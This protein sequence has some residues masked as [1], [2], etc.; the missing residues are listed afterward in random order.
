M[1]KS[2]YIL[3]LLLYLAG[4]DCLSQSDVNIIDSKRSQKS[5]FFGVGVGYGFFYPNDVNDYIADYTDNIIITNGT[6]D[7]IMNYTIR[8]ILTYKIIKAIDIS[9]FADYTWSP[10][11]IFVDGD[12][13]IYFHFNKFSPG[14]EPKFHISFSSGRHSVFFSPGVTYNIMKFEKYK[15]DKVGLRL[16]GGV[17]LNFDNF[18]MQPF[19]FYDISNDVD[20]RYGDN[21]RLNYSGVQL[22]VDFLF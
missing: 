7:M 9:F 21:F 5:L 16:K 18:T 14:I 11:L 1:K 20:E 8:G 2:L 10:K 4:P 6:T 12:D 22:G 3:T 17:G 19:V 15:A 13:N